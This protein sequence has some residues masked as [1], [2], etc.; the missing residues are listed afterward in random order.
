MLLLHIEIAKQRLG[1]TIHQ[2]AHGVS[3]REETET[4]KLLTGVLRNAAASRLVPPANPSAVTWEMTKVN[5]PSCQGPVYG[6]LLAARGQYD[7]LSGEAAGGQ[8]RLGAVRHFSKAHTP[9]A[10]PGQSA[11]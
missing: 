9:S 10:G 8:Q 1:Y 6:H 11:S 2:C 3:G 4:T 5:V 7:R